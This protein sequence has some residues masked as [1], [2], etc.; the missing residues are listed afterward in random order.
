MNHLQALLPLAPLTNDI[1]HI[2]PFA[3]YTSV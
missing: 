3:Y 1:L 2:Q